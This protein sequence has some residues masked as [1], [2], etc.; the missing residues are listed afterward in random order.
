MQALN[1]ESTKRSVNGGSPPGAEQK[2]AV[3]GGEQPSSGVELKASTLTTA[4]EDSA[5]IC[6]ERDLYRTLLDLG[7][8]D[9]IESLAEVALDLVTRISGARKG[10][11]EIFDEPSTGP[12]PLRWCVSVGCSESEVVGIQDVVSHGIIAEAVASGEPVVTA[13]AVLDQ[14][15][16]DRGSVRD[17]HIEAVLCVPVGSDV[18]KMGALYLQD[19]GA[20]G[21]FT[22]AE[23]ELCQT[24]ARYLAVF[25]ERLLVKG[26]LSD[27]VDPTR[28][29]RRSL[30]LSNFVG[31]SP[32]IAESLSQ[33]ALVAP[34]DVSVL[35]TGDSGTGKTQLARVIHDNSRR[36]GQPFVELNCAAIPEALL[37]SELFGAMPGAHSTATRRLLG[38]L[39][40][41]RHGTL[42]LDEVGELSPATQ[43]KMLQ[44][45]QSRDYYPLGSTTAVKA[46]VRVLAATNADLRARVAEKRFRE[47][48]LYRLEVLPLRVP[49]L[50][51]R[52]KDIVELMQFFATR[53]GQLHG[54][55]PLT[56]SPSALQAGV[57][58][59]WPGNVRQLDHAVAAG[60]IRAAGS[61][62]RSVEREHLFP[63]QT[64][65]STE[66]EQPLTYQAA[67]RRFQEQLLRE[68]LADTGWNVSQTAQR[69][70]V[71]RSHLYT[72]INSFGLEK[73]RE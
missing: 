51:E 64:G 35:I 53:A 33:I 7:A 52:P 20:R 28:P 25:A 4:E 40:A 19:R 71:A 57:S 15:F 22:D 49:S 70:D 62:A 54:F 67:T 18:S 11:L 14:R 17:N 24:C 66:P 30:K 10:Y 42:F 73:G 60:V 5:R 36:A 2:R 44:F 39:D 63:R 43:A 50:R 3:L 47:D 8:H 12:E 59:E 65:A 68:T 6:Q 38:K 55:T 1:R 58:A 46:D 56:L 9:S 13:S 16:R 61:G 32:A 23:V 48:L 34:L 37:E 27:E 45:L 29:F 26:R 41:A 69:L 21:P 72:L 31:R